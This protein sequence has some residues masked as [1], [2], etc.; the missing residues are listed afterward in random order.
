MHVGRGRGRSRDMMM[1]R[2]G[3][4]NLMMVDHRPRA[5]AILGVTQEEKEELKPH[6]V[7][8]NSVC[9]SITDNPTVLLK[10]TLIWLFFHFRN[11]ERLRIYVTK[12]PTAS[13]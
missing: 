8:F 1:A 12:M 3:A 7:V 6:F 4:V 10:F 2:G 13:S 9:S 11:L 5:L